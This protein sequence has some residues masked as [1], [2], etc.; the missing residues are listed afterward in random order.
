MSWQ[1]ASNYCNYLGGNLTSVKDKNESNVIRRVIF[2]YRSQ[3]GDE[4]IWIGLN[5][6]INERNFV[7]SDGTG[8]SFKNWET[9]EP[10]NWFNDT[11]N[12]DEDCVQFRRRGTWKWNDFECTKK[13]KFICKVKG[14]I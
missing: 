6:K 1:D 13:S 14:K 5:D 9:G 2:H 10:N 12:L 4:P 3:N 8:Y 7:W 11:L